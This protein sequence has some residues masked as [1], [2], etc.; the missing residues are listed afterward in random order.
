MDVYISSEIGECNGFTEESGRK[1]TVSIVISPL[2]VES[3]EDRLKVV[4][5]CSMFADCQNGQCY[6]S[7]AARVKPKIKARD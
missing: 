4:S 5:G 2:R 6:F 1:E 7:A 3:S